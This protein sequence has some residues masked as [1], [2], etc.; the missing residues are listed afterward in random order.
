VVRVPRIVKGG[1]TPGMKTGALNLAPWSRVTVG[2]AAAA[3][4]SVLSDPTT[5]RMAPMVAS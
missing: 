4:L 5:I 3:M 1:P 2:D